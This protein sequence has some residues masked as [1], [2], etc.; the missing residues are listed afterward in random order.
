MLQP[1]P[2]KQRALPTVSP[3]FLHLRPA[4]Q[5][6]GVRASAW[7]SCKTH[8][9]TDACTHAHTGTSIT[10]PSP[11]FLPARHRRIHTPA[12]TRASVVAPLPPS[13]SSPSTLLPSATALSL[14]NALHS[15][16]RIPLQTRGSCLTARSPPRV[17]PTCVP[18]PLCLRASTL[19]PSLSC[20]RL[21]HAPPS[22]LFPWLSNAALCSAPSPLPL[23]PPHTL[24]PASPTISRL[25]VRLTSLPLPF[26]VLKPPPF[27]PL[28]RLISTTPSVP[29][30][31]QPLP[32]AAPP[33]PPPRPLSASIPTAVHQR[34]AGE[35]LRLPR[36]ISQVCAHCRPTER[37]ATEK[38]PRT[39]CTSRQRHAHTEGERETEREHIFLL[40]CL[41]EGQRHSTTRNLY[42][43]IARPHAIGAFAFVLV[44][45]CLPGAPPRVPVT[46][47]SFSSHLALS[48]LPPRSPG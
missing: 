32:S 10:Q 43:V 21:A 3:P 19:V 30:R 14:L 25:L 38:R 34:H 46:S 47:H 37:R 29:P 24:T 6:C 4:V 1:P 15:A 17:L 8:N 45:L 42:R 31:R 36:S 7:R 40:V 39:S 11:P 16:R 22:H 13:S 48:V 26:F 12:H 2:S 33:P 41:F 35:C 23:T 44:F 28:T 9:H 27:A 5:L 18:L 20:R